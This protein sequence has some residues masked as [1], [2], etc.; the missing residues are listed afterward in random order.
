MRLLS[1]NDLDRT[2][3]FTAV[4]C[5]RYAPAALHNDEKTLDALNKN[6]MEILAI[7]EPHRFLGPPFARRFVVNLFA[8]Q[9]QF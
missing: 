4:V 5:F 7:F 2:A 1:R 6:I 3:T 9:A 8:I